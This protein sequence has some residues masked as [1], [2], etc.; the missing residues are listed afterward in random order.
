MRKKLPAFKMLVIFICCFVTAAKAT[1]LKEIITVSNKIV[2]LKFVDGQITY[3]GLGQSR[4]DDAVTLFPGGRLSV[5]NAGNDALYDIISPNDA[6]YISIVHPDSA[7]INMRSEQ[8]WA[9]DIFGRPTHVQTVYVYLY[10]RKALTEGKIYTVT[11]NGTSINN[12]AKTLQFTYS[13]KSTR[14][15]AVHVNNLGYSVAAVKKYAYI[16]LWM[17]D[18]GGLDLTDTTQV[19]PGA[20]TQRRANLVRVSDRQPVFTGTVNFRKAK[21]EAEFYQYGTPNNN[22]QGADVYDFDFSSYNIPGTYV[23]AVEGM[24]CSY[25]FDIGTETLKD[26]FYYTMKALYENR[27]GIALNTPYAQYNRPA[28]HNPLLTPGFKLYYSSVR[29]YDLNNTNSG[30]ADVADTPVINSNIKGLVN[31][32]GWYQ[33]AGDWDSYSSHQKIPAYLMFLFE[34]NPQ[35]FA[36]LPLNIENES[37]D[38]L[39]DLLNEARWLL[40]FYKRSKDAIQNTTLGG[41]GGVPGG[42]VFGDIYPNSDNS[43]AEDGKGSW[44]DTKRKWVMLGQD[45]WMTYF[46][47][48]IAAHFAYILQ[49]YNYTDPEGINWQQE[50]VSAWNWAKNN[51]SA[52]DENTIKYG[53]NLSLCRMYASASLYRLTGDKVNYESSYIYDMDNAH[54]YFDYGI[55]DYH[56]G[57]TENYEFLSNDDYSV[58]ALT[59]Y[60]LAANNQPLINQPVLNKTLGIVGAS[61][62][63]IAG[64]YNTNLRACRWGGSPWVNI[65]IGQGTVPY[66]QLGPIAYTIFKQRDAARANKWLEHMFTTADYFLGANSLNMTY[67]SGLGER[68]PEQF[69]HIDAFYCSNSGT[70]AINKKGIIP[71]GA[72]VNCFAD[73]GSCYGYPAPYQYYYGLRYGKAYPMGDDDVASGS[74]NPARPAHERYMPSRTSPI[75]NEFTIHQTGIAGPLA[76]GFLWSVSAANIVLPVKFLAFSGVKKGNDI[77]LEWKTANEINAASYEVQRSKDGI[78]FFSI[79]NTTAAGNSINVYNSTDIS[80][81]EGTN[82]YRIKQIDGNGLYSFSNVIRIDA[83]KL[84]SSIT[85]FPNPATDWIQ[86]DKRFLQNTYSIVDGTGRQVKSGVVTGKIAIANLVSGT[87]CLLLFD[88]KNNL[89]VNA[90]FIKR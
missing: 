18:K 38:G 61:A 19:S 56:I 64:D 72:M 49:Q 45:P 65:G 73:L 79:A 87:Y 53:Y 36:T 48:A 14:S 22:F 2:L 10:L 17:G 16:F 24:G 31:T 84:S 4:I 57:F 26:P 71:Y 68:S 28:P 12:A 66:I 59:M 42:R 74:T 9:L 30:D 39:P 23:V 88:A 77:L 34:T 80:P 76:Y 75:G 83:G 25:P 43:D 35:K 15:E 5:A 44:Q 1:N 7:G 37:A 70:G 27:S 8:T 50:A 69:F 86:I 85:L 54:A 47:A 33:D 29:H 60:G 67:V 40:R 51:S 32:W 20:A 11:V 55:N 81:Y 63:Y 6:N 21:T 82:Y 89:E 62:D 90:V 52:A 46:Y 13:E 58:F 41:T 3:H 78:N